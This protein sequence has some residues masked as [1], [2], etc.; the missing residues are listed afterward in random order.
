MKLTPFWQQRVDQ[1]NRE[2]QNIKKRLRDKFGGVFDSYSGIGSK[3]ANKLRRE[4]EAHRV[5]LGA[6]Q[7]GKQPTKA[8][9]EDALR[10]LGPKENRIDR[11]RMLALAEGRVGEWR[12][13]V[14]SSARMSSSVQDELRGF[15]EAH[16]PGMKITKVVP[17][18]DDVQFYVE[19]NLPAEK[20][21]AAFERLF[22]QASEELQDV[23]QIRWNRDTELEQF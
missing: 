18:S 15:R 8:E 23:F 4:L 3:A 2:V 1:E 19:T 13:T 12:F 6:A 11:V 17:K 14:R 7:V 21:D 22:D 5:A 16:T 10:R 20:I 9:I